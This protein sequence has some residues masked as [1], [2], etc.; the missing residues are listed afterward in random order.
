MINDF[1][2]GYC[3]KAVNTS[4]DVAAED[5]TEASPIVLFIRLL[6]LHSTEFLKVPLAEGK[7][8]FFAGDLLGDDRGI[9]APVVLK[10]D[11]DLADVGKVRVVIHRGYQ[12]GPLGHQGTEASINHVLRGVIQDSL[13]V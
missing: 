12:V 7:I 3:E 13:V 6:A 2:E 10:L 5:L 4:A 8:I 11:S 1:F 9:G